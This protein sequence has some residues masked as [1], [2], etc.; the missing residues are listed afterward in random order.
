MCKSGSSKAAKR[1]AREMR[2]Q[3]EERQA[4]IAEGRKTIEDAF[5]GYN[6]AFFNQR[7]QDYINFAT[8]QREEF[9]KN[10]AFDLSNSLARAGILDSS[11]ALDKQRDLTE[12]DAAMGR[13]I[14]SKGKQFENMARNQITNAKQS[15]L[16]QNAA[17]A[18]PAIAATLS[19]T[20]AANAAA[21]P[22]FDSVTNLAATVAEGLATQAELE[23][24]GQNRFDVFGYSNP[25]ARSS[26]RTVS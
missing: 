2:R 12:A 9:V 10:A 23:R 17:L 5:A 18:D 11:I 6:D 26:Y 8:P 7:A 4:R 22:Q 24:R 13:E 16:E 19:K 15:L 1:Q 3:E 14:A 25:Y 20:A 21:I